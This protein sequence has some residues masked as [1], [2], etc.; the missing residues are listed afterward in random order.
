MTHVDLSAL[1]DE[2]AALL[3]TVPDG[4]ISISTGGVAAIRAEKLATYERGRP[5]R[6]DG[7]II[8]S[9][10][11]GL[12]LKEAMNDRAKTHSMPPV[13]T[14]YTNAHGVEWRVESYDFFVASTTFARYPGDCGYLPVVNPQN[15]SKRLQS[16]I[17][18]VDRCT[19]RWV[20]F[21]DTMPTAQ[22]AAMG[23]SED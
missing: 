23:G 9:E 7:G 3:L 12:T 1:T 4:A 14:R 8:I 21:L 5:R 20:L 2:Q 6:E 15:P 11:L 19:T 22:T 10:K 13:G 18:E 17:S 16:F